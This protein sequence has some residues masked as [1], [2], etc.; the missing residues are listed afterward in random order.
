VILAAG[1]SS[2]M[3]R[4]KMLLPFGDKPMLGRVIE[5]L[6]AAKSAARI[7]V[8]SGHYWAEVLAIV[9]EYPGVES[10]FN[11]EYASGGM[12]SSVKSGLRSI[13][14]D[15]DAMLLLLGDQPMVHPETI[16]TLTAKQGFS[17]ERIVIPTHNAKRGHPVLFSVAMFE[18]ILGLG[19][20]ETLKSIVHHHSNV[21]AEVDVPDVSTVSDVDTPEDYE[22]ALRRWSDSGGAISGTR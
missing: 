3:G 9:A 15:C 18:P 10:V 5:S 12:L 14:P 21:V 20:D 7:V 22:M 16:R 6:I 1:M 13:Q 11:P 17:E 4:P 2:R 19:P 8:V